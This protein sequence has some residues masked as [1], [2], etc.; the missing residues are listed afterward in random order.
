MKHGRIQNSKQL[1]KT[2]QIIKHHVLDM[3]FLFL[4]NMKQKDPESLPQPF[5]TNGDHLPSNKKREPLSSPIV[6]HPERIE[7]PSQE[8]ESYVISITLRVATV[9]V[10]QIFKD[11]TSKKESGTEIGNSLEFDFIVPPPHS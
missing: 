8:P 9:I 7:L 10:Y 2:K 6:I 4:M 1:L 5:Q 11:I 3:V